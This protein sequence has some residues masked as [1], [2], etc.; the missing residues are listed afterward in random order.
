MAW[1]A[2][3]H[4]PP[5][6]TDLTDRSTCRSPGSVVEPWRA[7][8]RRKFWAAKMLIGRGDLRLQ[9]R[10]GC[11]LLSGAHWHPLVG[12]RP[13]PNA[14]RWADSIERLCGWA[15]QRPWGVSV[16]QLSVA[17]LPWGPPGAGPN[18]DPPCFGTKQ[19][20]S[21]S[22]LLSGPD[23]LRKCSMP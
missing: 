13:H 7:S 17:R 21:G 19:L 5:T 3:R 4:R 23:G 10:R 9:A 12:T 2:P 1:V 8:D 16:V 6:P 15:A 11:S 20:R 18:I 22:D 14:V